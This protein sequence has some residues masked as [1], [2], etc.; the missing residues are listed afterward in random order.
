[1][2]LSQEMQEKIMEFQAIQQQIRMV[3][4]QKYQ[5]ELQLKE[6]QTALEELGKLEKPEIHKAIGQ[7]LIKTGKDD[8]VKELKEKSETLELRLK[9]LEK[10]ESELKTKIKSIQ[11]RLQGV[12]PQLEAGG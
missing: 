6:A 3:V 11:D 7:I 5:M 1:M 12:I 4:S 8:V 2:E 10:Q 9:T